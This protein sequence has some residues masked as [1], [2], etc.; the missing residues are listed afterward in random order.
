MKKTFFI[1]LLLLSIANNVNAFDKFS[2]EYG[3]KN[4]IDITGISLIKDFDYKILDNTNLSLEFTTEYIKGKQDELFIISV[5]P[6]ITY[7]IN[8]KIYFEAG[9]GIAHF[10][11]ENLDKKKFGMN[12]QFK[13]SIGFAYRINK[14]IE[15][16]IKY[17]HYSNADL[18]SSN[19]GLDFVGLSLIFKF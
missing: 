14:T 9:L 15:T 11:E 16:K 3:R 10:T 7:D 5:Q 18:A 2:L 1:F 19:S 13:E 8:E 6:L 4:H 17:N 12:F